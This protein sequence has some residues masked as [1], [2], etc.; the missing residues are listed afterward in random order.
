V[1]TRDA[2]L[3]E[4]YGAPRRGPRLAAGIVVITLVVAFLGWVAWAAWFHATPSVQSDLIGYTVDDAHTVT[5]VVDVTLAS[6]VTASCVLRAVALDHTTVGEL[7]F[8]PEP[9]R[10]EIALRTDREATAV[11]LAGCTAPGQP[12][13]R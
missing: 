6:D 13:P 4:R 7:S 8:V 2:R 11:E 3:A 5:A 9:G 12:Q 10:N 1:T